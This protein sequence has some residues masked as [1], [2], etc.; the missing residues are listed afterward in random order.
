M[1]DAPEAV[2]AALLVEITTQTAQSCRVAGA[3]G[4]RPVCGS[5][6][7]PNL[8]ARTRR[9]FE[10]SRPSTLWSGLTAPIPP[11]GVFACPDDHADRIGLDAFSTTKETEIEGNAGTAC[12][13]IRTWAVAVV[14]A[15]IA[16]GPALAQKAES[17][18]R[19]NVKVGDQWQFRIGGNARATELDLTWVATSVTAAQI[20]ATENGQPLLLTP[21]LNQ[22]ESPRK[23]DSDLRLLSFPLQV[24]KAWTYVNDYLLKDTG[25][26]GQSKQSV[27]VL[28][29]EKVRVAAGEFDAFKLESTGSISGS[30]YSG[31]ISGLSSRT[32]W[33]AP[34]ARAI[35]KEE[36][37]DP[38]RGRYGSELVAFKLQP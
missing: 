23:T 19:P 29:Y 37:N 12:A 38:Y 14:A 7:A 9:T 10:A 27:L 4:Q 6:S 16:C 8:R 31:P 33:Y 34:A 36:I 1:R 17:A 21:D 32:Y 20:K 2:I 24:G 5:H 11:R 15:L 28:S 25:T 13:S 30:S 26:K 3:I 18:D 35:V 22:L